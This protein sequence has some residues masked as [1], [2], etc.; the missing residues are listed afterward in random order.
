MTKDSMKDECDV[1]RIVDRFA[2]TGL[3]SHTA[4]AEP[5]YGDAPEATLYEAACIRAEIAS[6]VEEGLD[7]DEIEKNAL[8]ASEDVSDD[9]TDLAREEIPP[10]S[11]EETAAEDER[12]GEGT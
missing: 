8:R 4:R 7:L 11:G 10:I 9:E 3:I 1:N 12:S 6:Q 2:Q 5:Q